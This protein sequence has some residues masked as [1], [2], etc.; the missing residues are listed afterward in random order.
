MKRNFVVRL[1]TSALLAALAEPASAQPAAGLNGTSLEGRNLFTQHCVVCHVRTLV[2]A[3]Q[4]YG[5]PLSKDSLGGQEDAL[6]EQISN[7]SP[8]MPGFRYNFDS[9]EIA[10]IIAYLKT[11]PPPGAPAPR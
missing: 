3:V 2:T 4:S 10:A 1:A 11:L 6:R 7:G 9:R 8:N 5:P